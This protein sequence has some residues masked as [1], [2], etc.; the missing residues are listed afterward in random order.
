MFFSEIAN[1]PSPPPPHPQQPNDP[2]MPT[3]LNDQKNNGA[4]LKKGRGNRQH[5][6]WRLFMNQYRQRNAVSG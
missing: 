3:L 5:A 1:N 4:R 6:R 2:P